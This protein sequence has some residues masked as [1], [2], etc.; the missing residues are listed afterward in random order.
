MLSLED[1]EN[2]EILKKMITNGGLMEKI[3]TVWNNGGGNAFNTMV[4]NM[5]IERITSDLNDKIRNLDS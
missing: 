5:H 1:K 2:V 3:R 4:F